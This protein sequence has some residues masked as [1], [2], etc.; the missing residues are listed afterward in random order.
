[1]FKP[2]SSSDAKLSTPHGTLGTWE[3]IPAKPDKKVSSFNSTRYIRNQEEDRCASI[4][5]APFN[6]TRYIRNMEMMKE[7]L[8]DEELSTPHGTLG[9]P[10]EYVQEFIAI[11]L[12]TPHGT[13]GTWW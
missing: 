6:S 11:L 8:E 1:M 10:E 3:G 5:Y 4:P 2:L 9:T 13:L 12:S 7:L